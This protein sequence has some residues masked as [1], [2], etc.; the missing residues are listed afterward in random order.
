[1]SAP[2]I[3]AQ[4]VEV[5]AR[6]HGCAEWDDTQH[7]AVL[8]RSQHAA[9]VRD[10]DA[11]AEAGMLAGPPVAWGI[12]LY[13]EDGGPVAIDETWLDRDTAVREVRSQVE[14]FELDLRLYEIREGD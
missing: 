6:L 12:G 7:N 8:K 14:E 4:A 2:D 10:I 1:M 9:I 3:R 13:S 11:L 5:L